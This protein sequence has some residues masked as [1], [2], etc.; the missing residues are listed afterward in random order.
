MAC[1]ARG[2]YLLGVNEALSVGDDIKSAA[3]ALGCASDVQR[4][5]LGGRV[6]HSVA[7]L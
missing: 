5:H 6:R 3:R 4:K 1:V 7:E 2:A